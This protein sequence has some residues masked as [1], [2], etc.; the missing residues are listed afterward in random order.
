MTS[1]LAGPMVPATVVIAGRIRPRYMTPSCTADQQICADWL[2]SVSIVGAR[3]ICGHPFHR[4]GRDLFGGKGRH[5][6]DPAFKRP[7]LF[8][9]RNND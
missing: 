5:Q 2:A 3:V 7:S 8:Q 9:D 4:K 1:T 6:R